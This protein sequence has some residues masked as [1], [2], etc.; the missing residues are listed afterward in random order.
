MSHDARKHLLV[1]VGETISTLGGRPN[2]I[3]RIEG[4][5]VFVGTQKS[6]QG[7]PVP[8]K[9]VQEAIDQLVEEGELAIEVTTVGYRS[10]FIGAVLATLPGAVVAEGTR[11]IRLQRDSSA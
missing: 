5:D 9:S 6:P 1:L 11:R 10:A 7:Q 8:I 2:T 4:D 3:L